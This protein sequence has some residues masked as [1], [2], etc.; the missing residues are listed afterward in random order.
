MG[1]LVFQ[2]LFLQWNFFSSQSSNCTKRKRGQG[3]N[4]TWAGLEHQ[5]PLTLTPPGDQ[6][7]KGTQ[8]ETLYR[9]PAFSNT[10]LFVPLGQGCPGFLPQAAQLGPKPSTWHIL[11]SIEIS[12][13]SNAWFLL[14]EV[15]FSPCYRSQ[16]D[17]RPL[18]ASQGS[19]RTEA[20]A[21]ANLV[22]HFWACEG[23]PHTSSHGLPNSWQDRPE[24]P[25]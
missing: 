4:E 8:H 20:Y 21:T 13:F 22:G 14:T 11:P 18:V 2:Y 7:L 23:F 19:D 17:H 9:E 3:A 15:C 24:I 12:E 16:W 5:A 25:T 6:G 10:L 1:S